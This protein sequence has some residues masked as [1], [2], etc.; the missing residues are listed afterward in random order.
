[1]FYWCHWWEKVSKHMK[2]IHLLLHSPLADPQTNLY[3]ESSVSLKFD[4]CSCFQTRSDSS[5]YYSVSMLKLMRESFI[6]YETTTSPLAFPTG[7][8]T[9][10][11]SIERA[12]PHRSSVSNHVFF[13]ST[14]CAAEVELSSQLG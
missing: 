11:L 12:L 9:N 13:L 5:A 2:L 4:D 7:R 6:A 3:R 8:S 10:N 14:S 1:M